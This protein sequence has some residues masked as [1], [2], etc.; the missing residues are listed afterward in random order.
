[1]IFKDAGIIKQK[2][3]TDERKF[4]FFTPGIDR[5]CSLYSGTGTTATGQGIPFQGLH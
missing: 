3:T 2:G 1:V 4:I 5:L